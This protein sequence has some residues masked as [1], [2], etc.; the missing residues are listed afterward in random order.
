[1]C[2]AP[3]QAQTANGPTRNPSSGS[4]NS[5]SGSS[6]SGIGSTLGGTLGGPVGSTIGGALGSAAGTKPQQSTPLVNPTPG[7]CSS[8]ANWDNCVRSVLESFVYVVLSIASYILALTGELLNI[9]MILNL[10]IKDFVDATP[11]IFTVWQTIRDISGLFFIFFLLYA[12]IQ[13]ILGDEAKFGRMLSSIVVAGILINFSF[14]LVSIGIDASNV[15]SQAI[16]NQMIPNQP[17]VQLQ[18]ANGQA[19]VNLY[20][21]AQNAQTAGGISDVFMNSLQITQIYNPKLDSNKTG[22]LTTAA[23][24]LTD[25]LKII[26]IGVTGVIMMFTTAASFVIAS[27]AFIIRLAVLIFILAFSPILCLSW[28]SPELKQASGKVWSNLQSQLTFMP[29]YLLLMYV[30]LSMLNK[31][32]LIGAAALSGSNFAQN[33]TNGWTF[34][35]IVMGINFTLVIFVLN[36]PLVIGIGMSGYIS[37]SLINKFSADTIWKKVG[38]WAKRNTVDRAGGA[39]RWTGS[40]VASRTVGRA[41]YS[42]NE[43]ITPKIA[44]KSPLL[45]SLADKTLGSVAN[46]GFG[47]KKGGYEDRLKAKKKRDEELNKLIGERMKNTGASEKD[48]KDAQAEFRQNLPWTKFGTNQPGGVLGFVLENRAHVDVQK[49]LN[50][51]AEDE[52]KK[53]DKKTSQKE[54]NELRKQ[55]NNIN[56][57]IGALKNANEENSAEI[58]KLVKTISASER[59]NKARE[60]LGVESLTMDEEGQKAQL[61]K[62]KTDRDNQIK[63]LEKTKQQLYKQME[64]N[65]E[66]IET[67]KEVEDKERDEKFMS[68]FDKIEKNTESKDK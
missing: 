42:L 28:M 63:D 16:Y 34:P 55:A 5:G 40:Q 22:G 56:D 45:G 59:V 61:N 23:G 8:F 4:S 14:F 37:D 33:N 64:T 41:A 31:S 43:K 12:A 10:H 54:N 17:N 21:V 38:S 58:E 57:L 35:F 50:K 11:A 32:N 18:G 60:T 7:T 36:L 66:K 44:S 27:G 29:V 39:A 26:T 3:A 53:E 30:A 6:L 62:F 1:M 24:I 20:T 67:G 9:T 13:M 51:K 48:I 2:S 49:K 68:R 19:G 15:I 25:A 47:V 52:Q 46:N 65:N